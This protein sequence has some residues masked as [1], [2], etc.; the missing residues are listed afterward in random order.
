MKK[1]N[2]YGSNYVRLVKYIRSRDVAERKAIG[3]KF[4]RL[5]VRHIDQLILRAIERGH[6]ERV[7][8]GKYRSL[9]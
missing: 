5:Q 7:E 8:Y 9:L 4:S 1:V 3:K 6:V 2:K